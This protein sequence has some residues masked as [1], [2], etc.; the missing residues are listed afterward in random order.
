MKKDAGTIERLVALFPHEDAAASIHA[1][2]RRLF[3]EGFP[4]AFSLP[5]CAPLFSCERPLPLG[6]LKIVARLIREARGLSRFAASRPVELPWPYRRDRG[7]PERLI[8]SPLEPKLPDFGSREPYSPLG[9]IVAADTG[10]EEPSPDWMMKALEGPTKEAFAEVFPVVFRAAFVAN[11]AIKPL[12]TGASGLS[13]E[14]KRGTP[15][16]LPK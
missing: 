5:L 11:I 7:F 8:V 15:A 2:R 12:E 13:F 6:E 4:G 14:W 16:W 10:T 9:L 3:A 1:F